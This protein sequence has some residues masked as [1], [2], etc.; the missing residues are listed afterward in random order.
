MTYASVK[1]KAVVDEML[2]TPWGA[3]AAHS[4]QQW[5]DAIELALIEARRDRDLGIATIL[6]KGDLSCKA[7]AAALRT[8]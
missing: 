6:D 3:L 4:R 2:A 7:V 8:H 1:A 5:V